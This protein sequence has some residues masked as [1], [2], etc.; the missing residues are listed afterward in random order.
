MLVTG[1]FPTLIYRSTYYLSSKEEYGNSIEV[2]EKARIEIPKIYSDE[3]NFKV[4]D[5][6]DREFFLQQVSLPQSVFIDFP[7][8]TLPG[9]YKISDPNGKPLSTISVNVPQSESYVFSLSN[10]DISDNISS[11]ISGD[12]DVLYYDRE[13]NI[14]E[15]IEEAK[16][17]TELWQLFLIL[18]ILTALT[19]M[20]VAR[21][22][23]A[24]TDKM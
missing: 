19:E 15:I 17:G 24:D 1:F 23:K 6:N 21:N 5:P 14:T 7:M 18:S 10:D 11:M 22:K 4:V 8:L 12:N 9:G 13:L 16:T 3:R 2:G 20:F